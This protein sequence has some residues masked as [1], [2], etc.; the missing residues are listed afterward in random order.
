[1]GI[2]GFGIGVDSEADADAGVGVGAY[3]GV[4]VGV[5]VGLVGRAPWQRLDVCKRTVPAE[6]SNIV[7]SVICIAK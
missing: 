1:M 2:F 5:G 6:T 4:G 3:F 7:D